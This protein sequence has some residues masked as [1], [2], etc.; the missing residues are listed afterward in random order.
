MQIILFKAK[1]SLFAWK[2]INNFLMLRNNDNL[3]DWKE[4][5]EVLDRCG[6]NPPVESWEVDELFREADKNGDGGIDIEGGRNT[7]CCE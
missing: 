6:A 1:P 7:Q 4:L 2:N 5:K 3:I